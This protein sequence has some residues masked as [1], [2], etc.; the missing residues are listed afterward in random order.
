MPSAPTTPVTDFAAEAA[1]LIVA[2][3]G[4]L[5]GV[6]RSMAILLGAFRRSH[7]TG[8]GDWVPL[9]CGDRDAPALR[10][11][12]RMVDFLSVIRS[13]AIPFVVMAIVALALDAFLERAGVSP[14]TYFGAITL[15]SMICG[16]YIGYR[17]TFEDEPEPA[18]RRSTRRA[19]RSAP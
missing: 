10:W 5:A 7:R 19:R 8:N 15:Y 4:V 6:A 1:G 3:S 13:W 11:R 17:V 2:I 9:G 14:S 12:N 18:V 16:A